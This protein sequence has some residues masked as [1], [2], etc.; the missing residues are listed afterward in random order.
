MRDGTYQGSTR[1]VAGSQTRCS[2]GEPISVSVVK[3]RFHYAWHPVQGALVRIAADGSFSATLGG[4]AVTAEKHMTLPPPQKQLGQQRDLLAALTG[5]FPNEQPVETFKLTNLAL[6]INLPVSLP[7]QLVAQRPD[8]ADAE[9]ALHAA[10]AQVGVAVAARWPQITLAGSV[11]SSA[12]RVADLLTPGANFWMPATGLTQPIFDGGTLLHKQCIAEAGFDQAAALYR[13]TVLTA[14]QNVA[15]TLHALRS[16]ADA[17]QATVAAEQAASRTLSITRQQ[18]VLGQ[19]AYLALLNAQRTYQ[20]TRL[21]V[22]Q[23][24]VRRYEDTIGL[25]QSLGGGWRN[26]ADVIADCDTSVRD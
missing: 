19:I 1:L 12:N 11:G 21:A 5:R 26:R 17:L 20:L 25:F 4:S 18:L 23:A 6:P 3:D 10:G 9:A 22:V 7:V 16:D 13:N 14:M 8:V 15:D 24:Q 2:V